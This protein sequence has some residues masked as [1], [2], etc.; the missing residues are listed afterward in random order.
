MQLILHSAHDD[1]HS[2]RTLQGRTSQ[3]PDAALEFAMRPVNYGLNSALALT[4]GFAP[5]GL[6]DKDL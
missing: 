5:G 3:S 6:A 4:C 1:S 2:T